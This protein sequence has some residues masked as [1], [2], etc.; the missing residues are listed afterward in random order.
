MLLWPWDYLFV[1]FNAA[2]FP[3]LY[4]PLLAASFAGL[5]AIVVF[6]NVRTRQLHR[7]TVYVQMYEWLLWTGVITFSLMLVY[8]VFA[9]DMIIVLATLVIGLGTMVWI[10]F[11]RFPPYFAAYERQLA[12]QRYFS[13]QRYAHPEATIRAKSSRRRRRR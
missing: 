5:I 8:V 13:R 1:S 6:Y 9:F 7:H 11:V 4:L 2:N 12:K 10:R 3:D